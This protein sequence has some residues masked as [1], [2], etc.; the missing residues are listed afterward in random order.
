MRLVWLV[1]LLSL[2]L[3]LE[4]YI[5]RDSYHEDAIGEACGDGDEILMATQENLEDISEFLQ[6][7]QAESAFVSGWNGDEAVLR[8]NVKMNTSDGAITVNPNDRPNSIFPVLC[9]SR[10]EHEKSRISK[11]KAKISK[12]SLK[13][14][15]QRRK[16]AAR[17]TRVCFDC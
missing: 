9:E 10:K 5:T 15:F 16:R 6:A 7:V 17:R 4:M 11:R 2:T 12:N 8:V 1:S 13:P 3:G 14:R